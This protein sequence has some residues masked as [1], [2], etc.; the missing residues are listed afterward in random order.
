MSTRMQEVLSRGPFPKC[1][2]CGSES[3]ALKPV[4]D[5]KNNRGYLCPTCVGRYEG[6]LS[7]ESVRNFWMCGV[8]GYR[9]LAGT[10]ADASV[11]QRGNPCP[12]CKSDVNIT[13]VNLSGDQP[14]GR[15]LIGEPVG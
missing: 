13:L 11:D 5:K 7:P 1:G 3:A 12:N 2:G 15:G 14:I 6:L 10:D 9:V 8:C 4:Q